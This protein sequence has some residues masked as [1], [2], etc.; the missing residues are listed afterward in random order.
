MSLLGTTVQVSAEREERVLHCWLKS[1][2]VCEVGCHI[3]ILSL[4]I[5]LH[6]CHCLQLPLADSPIRRRWSEVEAEVGKMGIFMPPI[7]TA[8]TCSSCWVHPCDKWSSEKLP[9]W[10]PLQPPG[11]WCITSLMHQT[12]P[13]MCLLVPLNTSLT[14][15]KHCLGCHKLIFRIYLKG[16]RPFTCDN[17]VFC[18]GHHFPQAWMT[19]PQVAIDSLHVPSPLS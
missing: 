5:S 3:L 16:H 9:W 1:A 13:T 7:A 10:L 14:Y 8:A 11:F 17:D 15:F 19:T 18:N 6:F 2:V 12:S 4:G